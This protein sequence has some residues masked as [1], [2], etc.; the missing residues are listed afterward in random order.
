MIKAKLFIEGGFLYPDR[1]YDKVLEQSIFKV[2]KRDVIKMD[3]LPK[4]GDTIDLRSFCQN[5]Y[6]LNSKKIEYLPYGDFKVCDIIHFPKFVQINIKNASVDP[7]ENRPPTLKL[8]NIFGDVHGH[9]KGESLYLTIDSDFD[10]EDMTVDGQH[11]YLWVKD[12]NG[13]EFAQLSFPK[14]EA[15]YLKNYIESFLA[16]CR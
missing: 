11:I 9:S 5:E 6:R 1:G 16:L 7:T 8:A 10:R 12:G 4:L 2:M 3:C 15:V 13:E 14:Q